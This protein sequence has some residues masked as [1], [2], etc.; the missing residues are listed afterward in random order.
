MR[1]YYRKNKEKFRELQRKNR[2]RHEVREKTRISSREYQAKPEI[3]KRVKEIHSTPEF[4]VKRKI[5]GKIYRQRPQN[6][7]KERDRKRKERLSTDYKKKEK[8]YYLKN[9]IDLFKAY[10]KR[11]SNSD[12]PCCACCGL[13]NHHE[14]LSID[15]ID[16]RKHLPEEEKNLK[17]DKLYRWLIRKNFPS[18]YQVLCFSCNDIKNIRIPKELS[19]S[20]KNIKARQKNSRLKMEVM[21]IYSKGEPKCNCCG[22]SESLDGLSIDHIEGRNKMGH[23]KSVKGNQLYRFL[24]EHH[25]PKGYQVLCHNCNSAKGHFG[26]CPHELDRM[27]N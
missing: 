11:I 19:Q 23:S 12:I 22:Y 8:G 6:K 9:K 1:E 18:G 13:N 14:F 26:K 17:G 4:K 21:K 2:L 24:I 20:I 7:V 27:K 10:S 3:K 15:H 16:G 25:F 5:Y